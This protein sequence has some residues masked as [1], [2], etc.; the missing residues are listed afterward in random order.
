MKGVSTILA[1][2]LIVIIVVAMISLVFTFATNLISTTTTEAEET[3]TETAERMLKSITFIFAT[4]NATNNVTKFTLR[5]TGT[6][7]IKSGELV[8]FIDDSRIT[9]SP[10]IENEGIEA[11][12]ISSEF[13]Y[14]EGS[15]NSDQEIKI[16]VSAPAGSID[17]KITCE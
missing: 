3:T 12:K 13:N 2:I 11:G 15:Y 7:D 4:C 14:T 6:V 9:T 1:V 16:T 5:H 17:K 10:N 8:A